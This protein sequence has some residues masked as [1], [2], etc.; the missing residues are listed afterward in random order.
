MLN[1]TKKELLK[2][3][4]ELGWKCGKLC[5]VLVVLDKK[6]GQLNREKETVGIDLNKQRARLE[7]VR[8][9]LILVRGISRRVSVV[10]DTLLKTMSQLKRTNITIDKLE[11]LEVKE[12]ELQEELRQK[13]NHPFVFHKEGYSGTSFNEHEDGYP[14]ERYCVVCGSEEKAKD[15]C[16]NGRVDNVGTVFETL[17]SS[18]ARVVHPEPYRQFPNTF[19]KNEIWVPLGAALK[20]FEEKV[21]TILNS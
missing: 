14:S 2:M 15:F 18:E 8:E 5:S 4:E 3:D 16:E 17:K 13:C 7:A 12:A 20:I 9:A 1:L 10:R 19:S 11:K 6:M 21:A